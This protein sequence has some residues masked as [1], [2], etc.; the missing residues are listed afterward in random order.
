MKVQDFFSIVQLGVGIHAGTALLQLSGE[1][2]LAPVE[3][4]IDN[5]TTWL[6]QSAIEGRSLPECEDDLRV[7]KTRLQTARAG[8]QRIY[9]NCVYVTFGFG[10]FLAWLLAV[11]SFLADADIDYLPGLGIVLLCFVPAII[12]YAILWGK[13]TKALEPIRMAVERIE[14]QIN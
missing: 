12:T 3:R 6:E 9:R 7:V 8:Y 2:G 1:F 5:L 13:V 4:R 11:M 10:I 14:E